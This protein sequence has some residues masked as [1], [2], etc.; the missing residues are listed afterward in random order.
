VP[1]GDA[2]D[3]YVENCAKA[4]GRTQAQGRK[5][6]KVNDDTAWRFLRACGLTFKKDNGRGRAHPI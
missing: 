4:I 1:L 2:I 3:K 6:I 5:S